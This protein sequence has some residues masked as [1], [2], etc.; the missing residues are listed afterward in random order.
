[1]N[2]LT[3]YISPQVNTEELEEIITSEEMEKL[4]N[5]LKD[6]DISFEIF[7]FRID[8]INPIT[9]K[10]DT[11]YYAQ[12]C[13]PVYD[14]NLRSWDAV[15]HPG[16]YG[17][18]KGLLEIYGD[19]LTDEDLAMDSVVGYLTAENVIYRIKLKGD[20]YLKKYWGKEK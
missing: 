9:C 13:C 17:F 6:N 7:P 1:M 16:S 11:H 14:L 8:R 5:Y 2:D 15:C 4:I 19:I 12:V 3:K 20:L 10:D 18:E